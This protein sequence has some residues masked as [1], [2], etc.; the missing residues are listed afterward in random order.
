MGGVLGF[1][2]CFYV[3]SRDIGDI[4]KRRTFCGIVNMTG[5]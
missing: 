4:A 1:P 3:V 5:F 2:A